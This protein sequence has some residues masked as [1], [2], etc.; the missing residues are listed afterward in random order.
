MYKY[1]GNVNASVA[2]EVFFSSPLKILLSK[3]IASV[4]YHKS[5]DSVR[6]GVNSLFSYVGLNLWCLRQIFSLMLPQ[7]LLYKNLISF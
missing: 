1:R 7:N 2:S 3:N 6:C 4:H 5:A